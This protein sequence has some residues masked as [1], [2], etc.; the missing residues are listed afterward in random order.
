MK[1]VNFRKFKVFQDIEKKSF[2][3][4]DI[5][6]QISNLL[7]KVGD[8]MMGHHLCHLIYESDGE[9]EVNEKQEE[10]LIALAKK[11]CTPQIID[12]MEEAFKV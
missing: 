7:Y 10:Y 8:G 3:E 9:I 2:V 5:V 6:N 1:K 12:S 4:I 11:E